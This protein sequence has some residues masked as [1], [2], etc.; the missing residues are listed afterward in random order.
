MSSVKTGENS[1]ETLYVH[2]GEEVVYVLS[3]IMNITI[4]NEEYI[5]QEGDT[6]QFN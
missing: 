3:G 6:I 1:S 5:L 2:V 4:G